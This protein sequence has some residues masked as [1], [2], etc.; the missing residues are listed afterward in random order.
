MPAMVEAQDVNQHMLASLEGLLLLI[1][2]EQ[3][4]ARAG[5]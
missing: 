1:E 2:R 3:E 5:Q 4:W